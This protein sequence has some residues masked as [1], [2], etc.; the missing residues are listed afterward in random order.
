MIGRRLVL[1]AVAAI[2]AAG[3]SGSGV[4]PAS[5]QT[6][7][8]RIAT[9]HP[10]AVVYAGQD[11]GLLSTGVEEARRGA[12]E[13][14]DQL[15]RRLWRL[16]GQGRRDPEGRESRHHRYRR[17][18]L[19]LRAGQSAAAR[20]PGHAAVRHHERET[21]VKLARSIYD[22]VPFMANVFEDKFNQQLIARIADN[23][24]NLATTFEWN[25][26][27]DLKSRK[28]AGAGLNLNWLEYAG[29]VPVQSSCQRPTRR[30][31]PA[32]ITAGSCSRRAS[33]TSSC[34]KCRRSIRRSAS[35]RSPGTG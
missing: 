8:L 27:G 35:A 22:R 23:G 12:H 29:V 5:A 3:L 33:S 31:R 10:P 7:T 16:D 13:V 15:G 14:Q 18:L 34:T 26:F 1:S 19:L 32:S 30:S 17:F 28:I 9:G 2:A 4:S 11:E 24:Y 25:T 20:V 6:I 21:S